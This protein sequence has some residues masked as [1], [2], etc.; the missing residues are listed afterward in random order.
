MP[1]VS[2]LRAIGS[3]S[4]PDDAAP[5][6]PGSAVVVPVA[7]AVVLLLVLAGGLLLRGRATSAGLA[8][9]PDTG[10]VLVGAPLPADGAAGPA[11]VTLSPAA[12]THPRAEE[13]RG[14][15]QRATEARNA[16]DFARWSTLVSSGADDAAFTRDT[17]SE[18]I[19]TV[20]LRRVDPVG[21]GEL[22][23]PTGLVTTQ[24]P[25]DAP[26]DLRVPRLC[27]QISLVVLPGAPARLV[28]PRPGSAL[29]TPC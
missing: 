23:V 5:A 10:P 27:W 4:A 2:R 6:G 7:L 3:R 18:R 16:R 28:E 22:V 13:I 9:L 29:R 11:T 17:R 24:D 1:L 8:A 26:P 14:L 21:A 20:V 25:A 12:A 15:V 19:G